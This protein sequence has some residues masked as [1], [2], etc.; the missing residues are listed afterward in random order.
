M[1]HN[2][3]PHGDLALVSLNPLSL[4]NEVTHSQ[5]LETLRETAQKE[6][7][8]IIHGLE[9]HL[10]Q[11]KIQGDKTAT[12]RNQLELAEMC[13]DIYINTIGMVLT[14][15]GTRKW[16]TWKNFASFLL[17]LVLQQR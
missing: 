9:H 7:E 1:E 12:D 4:L 2:L 17:L 11:V 16:N 6:S 15:L 14:M 10:L 5:V 13:V 3:N 8:T